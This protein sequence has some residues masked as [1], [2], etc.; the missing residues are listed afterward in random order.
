MPAGPLRPPVYYVPQHSLQ[1]TEHN[2]EQELAPLAAVHPRL[3]L[4]EVN[5]P[6]QDPEGRV[7]GWLDQRYARTLGFGFAHNALTLYAPAGE[8][9][10]VNPGNLAAQYSL[11]ASLG[12]GAEL[13]GYAIFSRYGQDQLQIVDLLTA[14]GARVGRELVIAILNIALSEGCRLVK[15]WLP[16]HTELHWELERLGFE[17]GSPITY[18]AGRVL[19]DPASGF[20]R[21]SF[22][23]WYYLMSDSDVY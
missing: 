3:W 4:A 9:A 19:R 5:A 17:N 16:V 2:V 12:A 11:S 6:M 18:F 23:R 14:A 22:E 21:E 13:L 10:G 1:V 15:L 7:E 8:A 20:K